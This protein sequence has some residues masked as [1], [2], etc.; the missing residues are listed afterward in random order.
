ME[1][2]PGSD[3]GKI[4]DKSY[5]YE[6]EGSRVGVGIQ[7]ASGKPAQKQFISLYNN[8]LSSTFDLFKFLCIIFYFFFN[9]GGK[10]TTANQDPSTRQ[11]TIKEV[12]EGTAPVTKKE[13]ILSLGVGCTL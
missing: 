4:N 13:L 12:T 8:S 2:K 5:V 6:K 10:K 3:Y 11:G 1:K 7:R 9:L